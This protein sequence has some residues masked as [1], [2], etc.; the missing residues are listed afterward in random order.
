MFGVGKLGLEGAPPLPAA[1]ACRENMPAA[2]APRNTIL[3]E[4]M[5]SRLSFIDLVHSLSPSALLSAGRSHRG[6]QGVAMQR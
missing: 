5:P 2:R 4:L 6:R 3:R 1:R